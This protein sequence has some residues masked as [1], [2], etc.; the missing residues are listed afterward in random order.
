VRSEGFMSMKN[1]MIQ[2]GIEPATFW[3]VAQYL[4]HCDTAV[5]LHTGKTN[6]II[7]GLRMKFKIRILFKHKFYRITSIEKLAKL[8]YKRL[9]IFFWRCR[10]WRN[11]FCEK[12]ERQKWVIVLTMNGDGEVFLEHNGE[13]FWEHR[14]EREVC[15]GLILWGYILDGP[16][17]KWKWIPGFNMQTT[18]LYILHLL[19]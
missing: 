14:N 12:T 2:S 11:A 3:F 1:S 9:Y 18:S 13:G 15:A 5:P 7:W 4:N 6:I 19:L 8:F 10:S 17:G 16:F